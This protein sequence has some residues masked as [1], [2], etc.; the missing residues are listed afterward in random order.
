MEGLI[1]CLLSS[2]TPGGARPEIGDVDVLPASTPGALLDLEGW[3]SAAAVPSTPGS[4]PDLDRPPVVLE[5]TSTGEPDTA[6]ALGDT[7][8]GVDGNLRFFL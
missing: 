1:T 8:T 4:G 7:P 3:T 2:K 5:T 6:V